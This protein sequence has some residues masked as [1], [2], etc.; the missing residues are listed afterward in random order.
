MRKATMFFI[1]S[2]KQI[3]RNA[4]LISTTKARFPIRK[5]V[6]ILYSNRNKYEPC[7]KLLFDDNSLFI[8]VAMSN[9]IQNLF[10][11]LLFLIT[12]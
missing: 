5:R 9:A 7:N 4:C 1:S 2:S 3:W 11:S 6:K 8:L 12:A 10:F